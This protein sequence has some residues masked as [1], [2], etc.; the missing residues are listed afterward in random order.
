MQLNATQVWIQCNIIVLH[1]TWGLCFAFLVGSWDEFWCIRIQLAGENLQGKK[2]FK[3][4]KTLCINSQTLSETNHNI[5]KKLSRCFTSNILL[6]LH[7][8][9]LRFHIFV[10]NSKN[11]KTFVAISWSWRQSA[12]WEWD[13]EI[14]KGWSS[15]HLLWSF[16]AF[17]FKRNL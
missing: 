17:N 10:S 4:L 11:I 9:N 13:F 16:V 7:V 12:I 5:K 2:K 6:K 14:C 8:P 15:L 3:L 1:K